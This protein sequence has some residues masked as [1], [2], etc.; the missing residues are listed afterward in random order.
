MLEICFGN[1][2]GG[3]LFYHFFIVIFRAFTNKLRIYR[4]NLL[5]LSCESERIKYTYQFFNVRLNVRQ[6]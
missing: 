1:A 5:R 3:I 2:V 4:F 6:I